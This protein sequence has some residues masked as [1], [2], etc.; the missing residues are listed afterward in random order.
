MGVKIRKETI[1]ALKKADMILRV[2]DASRSYGEE[3]AR[4]DEILGFTGATVVRIYT[5]CDLPIVQKPIEEAL[6]IKKDKIPTQKILN[7]I[8]ALLPEGEMLYDPEYYTDIS[9]NIRIGEVIRE[10]SLLRLKQEIPHALYVQVEDVEIMEHQVRIL[11]YI[12]VERES[13]KII[14]IGKG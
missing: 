11:A 9:P 8:A 14:V 3:D 7:Q 10:Q 1:I 6:I 2:I 12:V 4:I 13:Q 5:K